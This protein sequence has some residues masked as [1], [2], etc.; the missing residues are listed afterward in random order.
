ME[1]Q[2]INKLLTILLISCFFIFFGSQAAFAWQIT[3]KV[4]AD[5]TPVFSANPEPPMLW[6]SNDRMMH[7]MMVYLSVLDIDATA[8]EDIQSWDLQQGKWQ[9]A[10]QPLTTTPLN[11]EAFEDFAAL[12][13]PAPCPVEHR[14][15]AA[16]VAV[17]PGDN[18]ADIDNWQAASLEPLS[19]KAGYMQMPWQNFMLTP[20]SPTNTTAS[21]LSPVPLVF[22]E[23][24]HFLNSNRKKES[25]LLPQQGEYLL[26]TDFTRLLRYHTDNIE[27]PENIWELSQR[28]PYV[29]VD[30]NKAVFYSATPF[31]L[32]LIDMETD[33]VYPAGQSH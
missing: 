30:E 11:I 24:L 22:D 2:I 25:A 6:L 4:N 14:C 12:H 19:L 31:V 21:G 29:S 9:T 1:K 18:V 28:Y 33:T 15:F 20:G 32:Q 5:N 13:P 8:G 3:L 17:N 16:L 10:L 23:F 27:I 7:N 26:K